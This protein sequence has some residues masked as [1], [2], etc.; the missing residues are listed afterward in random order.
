MRS[1]ALVILTLSFGIPAQHLDAQGNPRFSRLRPAAYWSFNRCD[2]DANALGQGVGVMLDGSRCALHTVLVGPRCVQGRFGA[3]LSFDGLDDFVQTVGYV[4]NIYEPECQTAL[5]FTDE[6]TVSAWVYPERLSGLQTI[7]NKWYHQDSFGLFTV[8]SSF[9]FTVAFPDGDL[10]TT[11]DLLAPATAGRWSHVAGV[12][13]GQSLRLY[14]DGVERASA[15][16]LPG[17]VLQQ[18]TKPIVIGNHPSWNAFQGRIDEVA[19]FDAALTGGEVQALAGLDKETH[20]GADTSTHPENGQFFDDVEDGY[21]LY[22]GRLSVGLDPCRLD[23]NGWDLFDWQSVKGG[24]LGFQ[25][26]AASMTRPDRTYAYAWLV[27]PKHEDA[28]AFQGNYRLFGAYQAATLLQNWW[29]YEHVVG[30]RTL[31]ADLERC[32]KCDQDFSGWEVCPGY[33]DPNDVP[34]PCRRNQL[35]LEGFLQTVALVGY[36]Y[37]QAGRT[38][39]LPGVYTN[40]SRWVEFFGKPFIPHAEWGPQIPFPLWLASCDIT[41]GVGGQRS[42]DEVRSLL[43]TVEQ[44]ILGGMKTV[45]WQHHINLPD[46]D[47]TRQNPAGRLLGVP[48]SQAYNCTCDAIG[49]SCPP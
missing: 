42:V 36:L 47:A 32:R 16:N 19:L 22:A 11:V 30:G 8:G 49:G 26:D 33:D 9:A 29:K 14:V 35:V 13:D 24:C 4:G 1:R 3:G 6:L 10:G 38:P 20:F 17:D 44:T 37:A 5:D 45:I 39:V 21:D 27:G 46:W 40:A 12:F 31:F 28:A 2:L 41:M 34:A 7:V 15:T 25:Y 48:G 23:R 43:P 18:S